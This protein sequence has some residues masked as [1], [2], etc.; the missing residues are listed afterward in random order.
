MF[1]GVHVYAAEEIAII[2]PTN[3]VTIAHVDAIYGDQIAA[4]NAWVCFKN[5][6]KHRMLAKLIQSPNTHRFNHT[7]T[8]H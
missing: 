3:A 1:L 5:G 8:V 6:V 4:V 2:V 7:T